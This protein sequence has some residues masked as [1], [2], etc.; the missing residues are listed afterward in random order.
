MLNQEEL[1]MA[2]ESLRIERLKK[3]SCTINEESILK[4]G[5]DNLLLK[6]ATIK[7]S[8]NSKF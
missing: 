7:D 4:E 6:P 2:E 3:E 1:L 8:T 5:G